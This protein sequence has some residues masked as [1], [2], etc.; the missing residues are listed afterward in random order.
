MFWKNFRQ[1][2]P[3]SPGTGNSL[4]RRDTRPRTPG[5]RQ[6]RLRRKPRLPLTSRAAKAAKEF[7]MM[8]FLTKFCGRH[9][10]RGQGKAS[11]TPRRPVQLGVE[12]LEGREMMSV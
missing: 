9:V 3:L 12:A 2:V 11:P 6:N 4:M 5:H 7:A 8:S 10:G 1:T